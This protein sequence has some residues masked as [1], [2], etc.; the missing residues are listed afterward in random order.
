MVQLG[1]EAGKEGLLSK[2]RKFFYRQE[3]K[4]DESWIREN[5]ER[6]VRIFL[7]AV[8]Q[9]NLEASNR[10]TVDENGVHIAEQM[11]EPEGYK[12]LVGYHQ[13]VLTSKEEYVD[14]DGV[15]ERNIS[16]TVYTNLL[17]GYNWQTMTIVIVQVNADL[18]NYS[19]V[20]VFSKENILKAKYSWFSD[21]FQ[22]YD[23][24]SNFLEN[25]ATYLSSKNRTTFVIN[26]E[27]DDSLTDREGKL[28]LVYMRQNEDKADFVKFFKEFSKNRLSREK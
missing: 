21:V 6:M 9:Y 11:I 25:I 1:I 20:Y 22:I 26:G 4:W 13:D 16:T 19:N 15:Y 3:K 2:I 12:L 8:N 23:K 18:T 27:S 17:I 7:M 28:I 10:E 24:R 14:Y 5:R